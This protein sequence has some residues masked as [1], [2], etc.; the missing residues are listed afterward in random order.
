MGCAGLCGPRYRW[1]ESFE[2]DDAPPLPYARSHDKRMSERAMAKQPEDQGAGQMV[3]HSRMSIYTVDDARFADRMGRRA[4]TDPDDHTINW[5]WMERCR[6]RVWDTWEFCLTRS[7]GKAVEAQDAY[8]S[9]WRSAV[10]GGP[11]PGNGNGNGDDQMAEKRRD[12]ER[13]T[14]SFGTTGPTPSAF[15]PPLSSTTT[16]AGTPIPFIPASMVNFQHFGFGG[17]DT[18]LSTLPEMSSNPSLAAS[19]APSAASPAKSVT[20]PAAP[21]PP[22]PIFSTPA[23]KRGVLSNDLFIAPTS[24]AP[25]GPAADAAW[26]GSSAVPLTP[27]AATAYPFTGYSSENPPQATAP[28]TTLPFPL[29]PAPQTAQTQSNQVRQTVFPTPA[30]TVQSLPFPNPQPAMTPE[31]ES[32]QRPEEHHYPDEDDFSGPEHGVLPP[33]RYPPSQGTGS[34]SSLGQPLQS[35]Y[36][37]SRSSRG[38]RSSASGGGSLSASQRE[39]ETGSRP[40]YHRSPRGSFISASTSGYGSQVI[41]RRRASRSNRTSQ[42]S[43]PYDG[44]YTY[45][46]LGEEASEISS[47]AEPGMAGVGAGGGMGPRASLVNLAIPSS[48]LGSVTSYPPPQNIDPPPRHSHS[49]RRRAGT[50]P[51]EAGVP[52]LPVIVP[53]PWMSRTRVSS[54]PSPV[55][56]DFA[57]PSTGYDVDMAAF[58]RAHGF[59]EDYEDSDD[60]EG[61]SQEAAEKE[62]SIGLLSQAPSRRSSASALRSRGSNISLHRRPGNSRPVSITSAAQNVGVRSR[63]ASLIRSPPASASVSRESLNS[64]SRGS[65]PAA[66]EPRAR[67]NSG[68]AARSEKTGSQYSDARTHSETSSGDPRLGGND[69]TFGVQVDW[70]GGDATRQAPPADEPVSPRTLLPEPATVRPRRSNLGAS[71]TSLVEPEA[72][73]STLGLPRSQPLAIPGRR[74]GG[75][76]ASRQ[77]L[78]SADASFVT[79]MPA[80]T[81]DSDS[82]PPQSEHAGSSVGT[83]GPRRGTRHFAEG[84]P[85]MWG[86]Q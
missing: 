55:S 70:R 17:G 11:L 34:M 63:T 38:R 69:L 79:A 20:Q 19:A 36:P 62:D 66:P 28:K 31:A 82:Q 35:K 26:L 67:T 74:Y 57:S 78:S 41:I 21:S 72:G 13:L 48:P 22:L 75:A 51:S 27:P 47:G 4:F 15:S 37:Q 83:W 42:G 77:D 32:P 81:T 14:V 60:D 61:G 64:G 8:W 6:D 39:S 44:D 23:P 46:D 68:A 18:V 52:V 80:P 3:A 73:P 29:V 24:S 58:A 86:P 16:A 84:G 30:T 85:E 76:G 45:D 40:P 1:E 71:S 5:S 49:S 10:S 53:Q 12:T 54:V 56:R 43:Q 9:A 7:S 50:L 2:R 65:V 59:G 25:P 33:G